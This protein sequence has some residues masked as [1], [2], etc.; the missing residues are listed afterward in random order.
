MPMLVVGRG[1]VAPGLVDRGPLGAIVSLC[2]H[3]LV[4]AHLVNVEVRTIDLK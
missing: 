3:L 2:C 4:T 1:V